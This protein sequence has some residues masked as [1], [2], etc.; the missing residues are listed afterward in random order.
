MNNKYLYS[1]FLVLGFVFLRSSYGKITG[2]EFVNNL[3]ATLEKFAGKNPYPWFKSFLTDVAIPNSQL[4]GSLTMWGE[5]LAGLSLFVFSA[6]LIINPKTNK[7]V[8]LGLATGLAGGMFLNGIFWLAAGYTSPSTDGLN[9]VMFL[10]EAVGLAF[11]IT[12]M[13]KSKS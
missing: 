5:L 2:G 13:N 3:G 12:A 1:I 11:L 4:F 7:L 6:F 10:V 8:Y 9:L